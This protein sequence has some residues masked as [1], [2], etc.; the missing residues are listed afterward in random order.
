MFKNSLWC[1]GKNG[2]R[3][4]YIAVLLISGA[5]WSAPALA[6]DVAQPLP[7]PDTQ[8]VTEGDFS[9][10]D[11]YVGGNYYGVAYGHFGD[12]WFQADAPADITK[13]FPAVKDSKVFLPLL[14]GKIIAERKIETVGTVR[15]DVGHFKISIEIDQAQSLLSGVGKLAD[16][17]ATDDYYSVAHKSF[18]AGSTETQKI[19]FLNNFSLTHDTLLNKGRFSLQSAG[20][21]NQS[22]GYSVTSLAARKEFTAHEQELIMA[23]GMLQTEGPKFAKNLDFFGLKIGTNTQF[24]FRDQQ[25]Q[26][27]TLQLFLANRSKIEIYRDSETTGNILFS[28][29]LDFGTVEIDTRAF[30]SGSYNIEI[31]TTD[32]AGVKSRERRPFTKS[33]SLTPRG[34]PQFYIGAG[35]IRNDLKS[36][37]TPTLSLTGKKRLSDNLEGTIAAHLTQDDQIYEV[38]FNVEKE[39]SLFGAMGMTSLSLTGAI[40]TL[41]SPA[42]FEAS[43]AWTGESV[44]ATLLGNKTYARL[45]ADRGVGNLALTDR[46][47]LNFNISAPVSFVR[48]GARLGFSS[49]ISSTQAGGKKYRYGPALAM[50]LPSIGNYTTALKL[51]NVTSENDNLTL[52]SLLFRTETTPWSQTRDILAQH[53]KAG[54][55]LNARTALFFAGAQSAYTDWRQNLRA[56]ASLRADP[57]LITNDAKHTVGFFDSDVSYKA[58]KAAVLA[59]LNQNLNERTGQFG[60]EV[61][62]TL[63]WSQP[64]GITATGELISA[65]GAFAVL[66]LSGTE[67]NKLNIK[68]NGTVRGYG[69]A[70]ETVIIP[71]PVYEESTVMVFDEQ[72]GGSIKI[73]EKPQK[74]VSYPGNLIYREFTAL[75]SYFVTGV[76]KDSNNAP[77]LSERFE[78]NGEVYYTDEEGR[79]SFESALEEKQTLTFSTVTSLCKAVPLTLPPDTLIHDLGDISCN[80]KA[81]VL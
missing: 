74:I 78:V 1:A 27:S 49:E 6:I 32:S 37:D 77:L 69:V 12:N 47:S 20:N 57:L 7:T 31:V 67:K 58:K 65:E 10:F 38:G 79:F 42:G 66:K 45:S 15:V 3:A 22:T 80:T 48:D 73:K 11:I 25:G 62:S 68:V 16:L 59:Y 5:G 70:G 9:A 2:I 17:K 14:E 81:P 18:L 43:A 61:Q 50:D 23:G 34:A 41:A 75:K 8:L 36:T 33:A 28:R 76:L 24:I 64:S 29:S 60:G 40:D 46:Q 54:S 13:L 21:L 72:G 19:D 44:S 53:E 71:L 26:A 52:A 56:N 51:E 4:V 35:V 55:S 39:L 30:P 63:L